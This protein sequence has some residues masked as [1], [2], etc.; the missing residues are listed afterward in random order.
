VERPP[1]VPRG[2]C[3]R[4]PRSLGSFPDELDGHSVTVEGIEQKTDAGT[5]I[6]STNIIA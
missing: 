5:G 6:R 1:D 2:E 4:G 3:D